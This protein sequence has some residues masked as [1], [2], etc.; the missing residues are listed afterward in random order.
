VDDGK[1][2]FGDSAWLFGIHDDYGGRRAELFPNKRGWVLFTEDVGGNGASPVAAWAS[3]PV[4]HGVLVRLNN[5]YNDGFRGPGTIPGPGGYDAFAQKCAGWVQRSMAGLGADATATFIIGNEMN[6]PREWPNPNGDSHTLNM[7]AAISPQGYA[8]CFNRVYRAIKAVAPNARVV[9]GAVDPYNAL[10]MDCLHYFTQMLARIEALDGFA[11]HTYTHGP[12]VSRISS[13][14]TFG[15]DPL[16]WQYY[17][18]LSYAT[19]MDH[20]PAKWRHVPVYLTETDQTP[21]DSMPNA[22]TGGRNGWV[23]AAYSE[24]QR[25]N[26]QPYAQQIQTL[27][28]YRFARGGGSD[29]LYCLQ[30]KP[31]ILA[32]FRDTVASTDFRWRFGQINAQPRD[33]ASRNRSAPSAP[34]PKPRK[35]ARP[36]TRRIATRTRKRKAVV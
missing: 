35:T 30:D 12:D 33:V 5:G 4:A 31:D 25:W 17:D 28:L 1:L 14:Q 7:A 29:A 18:F 26:A 2:L 3:N 36:A 8:D 19:L 21:T 34:S 11:F 6:N 23:R 16:R 10:Y 20:V 15:N 22:W 32:E 9:P 13:L 27:I 24:I